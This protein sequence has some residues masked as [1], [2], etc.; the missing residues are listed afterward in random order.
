MTPDEQE[1]ESSKHAL[2]IRVLKLSSG[3][4][5]Y[6]KDFQLAAITPTLETHRLEFMLSAQALEY[7]AQRNAARKPRAKLS[8]ADLLKELGL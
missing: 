7:E 2:G 8:G 3:S 1:A 5:A 6:F 4:W